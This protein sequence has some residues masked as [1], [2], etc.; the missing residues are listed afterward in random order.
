MP[1]AVAK[2]APSAK[3][4]PGAKTSARSLWL[5]FALA[6]FL[7]LFDLG[8]QELW[9]DEGFTWTFARM[10]SHFELGNMIRLEPTPPLYYGLIGLFLR[11]FGD[12]DLVLRLPSALCGA[13]SI[14]LVAKLGAEMGF[15]RAGLAAAVLL[16][17]HPWH[18]F[19]SREARVYP[20]LMLLTLAFALFLWRAM[21]SGKSK[22]YF[23]AGA[24]LVLCLYSHLFGLFLGLAAA[25]LVAALA[26]DN[27]SRLRGLIA[28]AGAFLLLTPYL[29]VALP[30]LLRSGANWSQELFYDAMP[31]EHSLPRVLEGQWV[32]A[33][34]HILQ[35]SLAQPPT[36]PLL[37]WPALGA[38]A[39]FFLAALLAAKRESGPTRR[40]VLFLLTLYLLPFL[41]PWAIGISSAKVFFQPGRHDFFVLGP[42]A[43]LLALGFE[44]IRQRRKV[45]AFLLLLPIAGSGL[46]R[47][48]SIY[49]QPLSL[50]ATKRGELLASQAET[51][52]LAICFGLERLLAERYTRLAGSD[53]T[54]ESFPAEIDEH[55]G[56][57]DPRPLLRQMPQLAA[58]AKARVAAQAGEGRIFTIERSFQGARRLPGWQIDELY[59]EA[60]QT[61]GWRSEETFAESNI[62]VWRRP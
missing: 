11:L 16:T 20:L 62:R 8:R 49:L 41:L 46:F 51:G 52:D 23:A 40:A 2:P 33:R 9:V 18:L 19:L 30:S 37:R 28:L 21:E 44:Q 5:L 27:A 3:P 10:L 57:S 50:D 6:L 48:A 26:R 59:L 13:L 56:W 4:A 34:Y 14:P 25:L 15:R 60:L 32:G 45:L 29:I 35:R 47:L 53:L 38:Q 1:A 55:P 36:P 39:L 54:F 22:D 7:R 42:L 43:L 61:S 31:E 24:L 17:F 12:H 58:E